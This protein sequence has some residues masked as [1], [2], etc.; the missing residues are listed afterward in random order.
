M[1]LFY[2]PSSP[3]T[4][5]RFYLLCLYILHWNSWGAIPL[6]LLCWMAQSPWWS[7]MLSSGCSWHGHILSRPRSWGTNHNYCLYCPISW[8][9]QPVLT[10]IFGTWSTLWCVCKV[11]FHVPKASSSNQWPQKYISLCQKV[12]L[13]SVV[14]R[15]TLANNIN[16]ASMTTFDGVDVS[17]LSGWIQISPTTSE[18]NKAAG[19]YAKW[20]SCF[21]QAGGST[22]ICH[23]VP[24]SQE[25]H[26]KTV[27]LCQV[28]T[29][30]VCD[31]SPY[32]P[33]H[34]LKTPHIPG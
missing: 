20:V 14:T 5:P 27:A 23:V 28:Y 12:S 18:A 11:Q 34:H 30:S 1:C 15:W 29:Q 4:S 32:I 33:G 16:V 13:G 10:T 25:P 7:C 9:P 17:K 6:P 2:V 26:I 19:S 22:H 3:R 24:Y 21:V 31:Y 8:M